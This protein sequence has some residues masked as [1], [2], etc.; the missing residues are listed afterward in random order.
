MADTEGKSQAYSFSLNLQ[1]KIEDIPVE[2]P[3]KNET[4]TANDTASADKTAST[5]PGAASAAT[6]STKKKT[7]GATN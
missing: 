5:E 1:I 2:E 4:A 3:S 7:A 6:T